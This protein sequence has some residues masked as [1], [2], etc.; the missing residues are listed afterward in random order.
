MGEW[1]MNTTTR[2]I[3]KYALAGVTLLAATPAF[4]TSQEVCM[5]NWITV[6]GCEGGSMEPGAPPA[7]CWQSTENH[8]ICVTVE[9]PNGPQ[10]PGGGGGPP[11]PP[12]PSPCI[13]QCI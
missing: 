12:N 7:P 10:M 9:V 6:G 5:D 3:T 4:A 11:P 8:P 1:K 13:S 2:R